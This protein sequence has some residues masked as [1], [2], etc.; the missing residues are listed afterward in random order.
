MKKLLRKR[1]KKGEFE[2]VE[3]LPSVLEELRVRT[4]LVCMALCSGGAQ[5]VNAPPGS[6]TYQELLSYA[7]SGLR[8]LLAVLCGNDPYNGWQRREY[9]PAWTRAATELSAGMRQK[10]ASQFGL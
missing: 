7:P 9:N 2:Y 5:L 4:G 6:A 10:S 3:Y 1:G 8:C